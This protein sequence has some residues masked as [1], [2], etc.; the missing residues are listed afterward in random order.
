M[1]LITPNTTNDDQLATLWK[2]NRELRTKID[3]L[4]NNDAWKQW[5]VD[6]TN[7]LG[8]KVPKMLEERDMKIINVLANHTDSPSIQAAILSMIWQ[9][10][11]ARMLMDDI[12]ITAARREDRL[13]FT[14]LVCRVLTLATQDLLSRRRI[15]TNVCSMLQYIAKH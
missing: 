5:R 13:D 14:S 10:K 8:T 6:V 11:D 9:H 1:S 7:C 15:Y 4:S 2:V 3:S 12:N